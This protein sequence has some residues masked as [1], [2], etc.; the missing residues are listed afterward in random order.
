MGVSNSP[1]VGTT[2]S[3]HVCGRIFN[4]HPF[5]EKDNLRMHVDCGG[6]SGK[7]VWVQLPGANRIMYFDVEINRAKPVGLTEDTMVCYG[8]E[9]RQA[10]AT[11]PEFVISDDVEDPIFYST[12]YARERVVDW[13]AQDD[14]EPPPPRWRYNHRCISCDSFQ[15]NL[16]MPPSPLHSPRWEVP[17]KCDDCTRD[18]KPLDGDIVAVATHGDTACATDKDTCTD[19]TQCKKRLFPGGRGASAIKGQNPRS[20]GGELVTFEECRYLADRDPDCS[21]V[22]WHGVYEW[23]ETCHCHRSNACCL[24]CMPV[25]WDVKGSTVYNMD[26]PQPDSDCT[27]GIKSAD[28]SLCCPLE[29]GDKCGAVDWQCNSLPGLSCCKNHVQVQCSEVG[30]PCLL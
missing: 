8:V 30:A 18:V 4:A 5:G 23:G 2:C 29:C 10:S 16:I 21:N 9:A 19:S 20:W 11:A 27:A 6:N 26:P 17:D 25:P 24:A 28:G 14:E 3:G 1:C 7:Y 15:R 12:C 22:F 13:L